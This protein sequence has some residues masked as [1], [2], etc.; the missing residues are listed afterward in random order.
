M[1]LGETERRLRAL[2]AWRETTLFN[3]KEKAA[4]GIAEEIASATEKLS[5]E[6]YQSAAKVLSLKSLA[7]IIKAAIILTEWLAFL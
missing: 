2:T 6:I 4:L 3:K 5:D 1:I 7:Q